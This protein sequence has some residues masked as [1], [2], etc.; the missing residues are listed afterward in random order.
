MAHGEMLIRDII[1]RMRHDGCGGRPGEFNCSSASRAPAADRYGGL[2]CAM[3]DLQRLHALAPQPPAWPR[4]HGGR[5][6][7]MRRSTLPAAASVPML[8]G[9]FVV[10]EAEVAASVPRLIVVASAVSVDHR[11]RGGAECARTIVPG[12]RSR[13]HSSGH[14]SGLGLRPTEFNPEAPGRFHGQHALLHSM[15]D[16]ASIFSSDG[17]RR[18][19][20]KAIDRSSSSILMSVTAAISP[21]DRDYGAQV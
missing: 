8:P 7:P 12:S 19:L 3:P 15:H 6:R 18:G 1:E 5:L 4:R 21:I 14:L 13:G 16:P 9:C 17:S 2:S 11:H 10:S 20:R